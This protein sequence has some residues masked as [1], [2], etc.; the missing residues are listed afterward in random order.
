MRTPNPEEHT[1]A[2]ISDTAIVLTMLI[3][4]IVMQWIG[5]HVLS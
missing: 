3:A 1:V 5:F 4:Y 2:K